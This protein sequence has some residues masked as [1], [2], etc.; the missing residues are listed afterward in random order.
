MRFGHR[1][2]R[3]Y[4]VTRWLPDSWQ[5]PVNGNISGQ[6]KFDG[7]SNCQGTTSSTVTV[8]RVFRE[9]AVSIA[10][11]VSLFI[12]RTRILKTIPNV[13]HVAPRRL[14]SV[15]RLDTIGIELWIATR[16]RS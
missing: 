5:T 6:A 9:P 2:P 1:F 16:P 7:Y 12:Q 10:H 8:V 15:N 3:T 14:V 13:R 11:L 4:Q